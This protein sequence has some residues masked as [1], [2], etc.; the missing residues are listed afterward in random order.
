MAFILKI[1]NFAQENPAIIASRS[2]MLLHIRLKKK[3]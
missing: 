2:A 1:Q 3:K